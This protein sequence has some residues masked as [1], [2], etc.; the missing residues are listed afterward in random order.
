MHADWASEANFS[1]M[2]RLSSSVLT[3]VLGAQKN[4]IIDT[5]VLSTHNIFFGLR[6]MKNKLLLRTLIYGTDELPPLT[7]ISHVLFISLGSLG[8]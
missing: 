5:V 1:A 3:R 4:C 7:C 6:N 2:L 8:D